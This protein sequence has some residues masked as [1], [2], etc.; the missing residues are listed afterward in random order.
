MKIF[1]R[2]PALI[3]AMIGAVLNWVVTLELGWLNAGQSS[4]IVTFLTAAAIA[5]TTRPIAPALFV[6]VVS[7]GAALFAEYNL[8]WSDASVTGLGTVI[9]A[10]FALFGI[11]SQVTPAKDQAPIA[12][13]QGEVR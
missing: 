11:R 10:G 13:A 7:A 3:I 5:Y 8:P 2:E 12:P 9:L 1:G 6:A 4:A